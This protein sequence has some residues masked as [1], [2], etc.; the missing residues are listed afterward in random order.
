MKSDDTVPDREEL[1]RIT[2]RREPLR[3]ADA[4][5]A[6]PE[7]R[8]TWLT[9]GR[10]LDRNTPEKVALDDAA[11]RAA[12]F[13]Q[14]AARFKLG[15]AVILTV[16]ALAACLVFAVWVMHGIMAKDESSRPK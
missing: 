14:P 5:E 2:A 11:V 13:D 16:V 10:L 6:S 15:R 3:L 8:E 12:L 4:P 7:L 9:L 1:E